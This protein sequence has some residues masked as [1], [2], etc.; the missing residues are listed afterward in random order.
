MKVTVKNLEPTHVAYI[1]NIGT[2]KGNSEL[3]G[4]VIGKLCGRAGPRGLLGPNAKILTIY[5]DDPHITE[6]SKLRRDV[7]C[8]VPQDT[9]VDGEI[10]KQEIP[11]GMYAVSRFELKDS[12]EYEP[13]RNSVFCDWLPESDYLIDN[14]PLYEIYL[15]DPKEDPEGKHIIEICIPVKPK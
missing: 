10:S 13:A 4:K 9:K 14:R 8:T 2:Y 6:E 7:C 1:R 12:S 11:G 15:N 3:F 5:H